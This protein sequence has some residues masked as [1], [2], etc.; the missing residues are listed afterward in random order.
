MC[1]VE[2]K[3]MILTEKQETDESESPA[4]QRQ[5]TKL[6]NFTASE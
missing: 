5:P 4:D 3:M 6:G 2:T 1:Q